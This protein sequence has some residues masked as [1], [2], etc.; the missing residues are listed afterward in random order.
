MTILRI[1]LYT[2]D[3]AKQTDITE[4]Q[5]WVNVPGLTPDRA[6]FAKNL[7]RSCGLYA[8]MRDSEVLYIGC[9]KDF[10]SR[11][12]SHAAY[13]DALGENATHFTYLEVANLS[14]EQM[15]ELEGEAIRAHTPPLN[16]TVRKPR[17]G[18][19]DITDQPKRGRGRPKTPIDRLRLRRTYTLPQSAIVALDAIRQPG[20]PRSIALERIIR[21]EY[22]RTTD[23][24]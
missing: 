23:K 12:R 19:S 3:M 18:W 7:P 21:G 17:K 16:R 5:G 22:E 14:R 2:A 24:R 15:L 11:I 20:E 1:L 8:F 4:D 13:W 10:R 9:T 6:Q